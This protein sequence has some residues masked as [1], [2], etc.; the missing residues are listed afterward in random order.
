MSSIE[1]LLRQDVWAVVGLSN[2]QSRAAYEVAA[3]LQAR[4]K[5]I[6]PQSENQRRYVAVSEFSDEPWRFK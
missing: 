6:V 5:R 2:D 3:F 1:S 4:G